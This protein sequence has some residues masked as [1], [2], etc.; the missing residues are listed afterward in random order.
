MICVPISAATNSGMRELLQ[1]A[2][3]EPA[4]LY[5]IRFDAL[6]E[7]PEVESLIAAA[8][9]PVIATCRSVQEGGGHKGDAE[10]RRAVLRRAVKAGAAYIDLEIGDLGALEGAGECVR[11][12]SLHDF[13]R[14]PDDLEERIAALE[15]SPA[16]WVKFAVAA[17]RSADLLRVFSLLEGCG[18]PAIGIAMGEAGVA[19][20]ILGGRYGSRV[21]FGSMGAGLES[22]PGQTTAEELATLY[23]VNSLTAKTALFG[24]LEHPEEGVEP[25]QG[26]YNRL[27]AEKGMDA[28]CV[29]FLCR[30]AEEFFQSLP[31][32]LGLV[33]LGIGKGYEKAALDWAGKAGE[34]AL[35]QG[36]ANVL[37]KLGGIWKA[38]YL[39]EAETAAALAEVVKSQ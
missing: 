38:E 22:A 39:N 8:N 23:R 29:P 26:F 12:V 31:E 1:R 33:W 19:S 10:E 20:R 25:G 16:E 14:V 5:E 28:V 15:A 35:Q 6:E 36:G 18:K 21:T 2:A 7:A 4:E 13:D 27:F 30:D 11:I 17:R 24:C 32:G 37:V 34:A 3:K 9:R